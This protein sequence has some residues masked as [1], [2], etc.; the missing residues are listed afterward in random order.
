MTGGS[1]LCDLRLLPPTPSW[2]L[3]E[4]PL[5]EYL[6]LHENTGLSFDSTSLDTASLG[7]AT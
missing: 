1:T 2:M 4:A 6:L 5:D 7:T 3:Q